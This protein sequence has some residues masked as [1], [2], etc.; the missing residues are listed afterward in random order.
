MPNTGAL[1]RTVFISDNLPFL[2]ALDTESIDL[3]V[4]DPPFGKKQTFTGRI[5]P[6]LSKQEREQEQDLMVHWGVYD[7]ASAYELGVEYPDQTGETALFREMW[8]FERVLQEEW[9]DAV[10]ET[11]IWW[12]IE[13]TRRTHDE[14][15]AA[16]IAFMSQRMVEI[17]RI[18]KP[19]GSVYLHCDHDANAY[20]R[21]MMDAV[22]GA[23][24]FLNE[25]TWLRTATRKGNVSRRLANDTDTILRYGRDASQAVWNTDAVVIPYD[26]DN[27]PEKTAIKYR[28]S[29]P[30]GRLWQ[31]TSITSPS[32]TG[33]PQ[34]TFEV[35]GVT[36]T[37]RWSRER[38]QREIDNGRIIQSKP[39]AVPRYKRY[40][41]E[42]R[43]LPLNNLWTDIPNLNSM[44]T[45]RT[46]YPTQKPQALAAR[47]IQA[48]SNPGDLVLDCF[49]GCAYVPVAAE[50]LGRRWI[51]C[52]MSPRAWTVVRRQFA[53]KPEL[54]MTVESE[55]ADYEEASPRFEG[56]G[57]I[58]VRGP[59]QLPV[60]A[61]RE[62]RLEYLPPRAHLPEIRFRQ[63]P[64][65]DS[66][67]IWQIFVD[68]WGTE[69][70]Y[71]GIRQQ[72][73]RRYLQLDHIVPNKGD[74]SNDD[75]WNRALACIA[76]NSDKSNRLTPAQTIKQA[77]KSGRIETERQRADIERRFNERHKW[78]IARW[79]AL[80]KPKRFSA[81][82]NPNA[83]IVE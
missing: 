9:W 39:G 49:A 55:D 62:M 2:Q 33:D 82:E 19:T 79:K 45:E 56:K 18:L 17:R 74:G 54:G 20:L 6:P 13:S 28:H 4:I 61:D 36:R 15:T 57:V 42:Q 80:P 60:R 44:A 31:L 23:S 12:L 50:I 69:C 77:L 67:T 81:L 25:I 76:C 68:E 46:G 64:L 26:L 65:E 14:D 83:D 40:L 53:K 22:F 59:N 29:D 38:I 8:R 73:D 71:C 41:D 11:P 78:A 30:D 35:M 32:Q 52:D 5:R 70:W 7:I 10:R 66:E 21:Q 63:K 37:W 34:R 58:K 1:N 3:V 27:L 47:I 16:Y 72:P 75:C 43:G 24:N 51:A 48:S